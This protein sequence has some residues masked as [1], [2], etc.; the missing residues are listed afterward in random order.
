LPGAAIYEL[1]GERG[2]IRV[3]WE[4]TEP[5]RLTRGFLEAPEAYLRHVLADDTDPP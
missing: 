3:A 4:D 1:S 2:P 5:V